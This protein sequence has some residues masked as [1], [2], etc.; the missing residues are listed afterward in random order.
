MEVWRAKA[1]QRWDRIY[2]PPRSVWLGKIFVRAISAVL[3]VPT[4]AIAATLTQGT[5]SNSWP[6]WLFGVPVSLPL[7]EAVDESLD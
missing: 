5:A 1:M 4:I 3:C 2:N 6:F 7:I